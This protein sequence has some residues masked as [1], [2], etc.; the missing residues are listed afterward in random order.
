MHIAPRLVF[1]LFALVAIWLGLCAY[2]FRY[3][4]K[5]Q[6]AQFEALG[7]PGFNVRG[8]YGRLLAYLFTR[9]HRHLGSSAFSLL[10][11]AMLIC[12]CAIIAAFI[13]GLLLGGGLQ[14]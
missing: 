4:E 13:S 7:S 10:C 11:D 9:S 14:S 6:P 3:T 1:P 5:Y 8:T 2:F 12:F